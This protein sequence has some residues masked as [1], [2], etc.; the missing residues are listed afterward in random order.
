M[1]ALSA[2]KLGLAVAQNWF[3]PF[4][5]AAMAIYH[6]TVDDSEKMPT[7][8]KRLYKEYDFIIIGEDL[9]RL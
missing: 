6:I 7:N 4:L 2:V 3:V 9:F 1:A 8:K 5:A